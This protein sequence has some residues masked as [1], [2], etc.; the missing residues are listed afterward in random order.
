L[1]EWSNVIVLWGGRLAGWS[2]V[3]VLSG[4]RL[5]A[6]MNQPS[7]SNQATVIIQSTRTSNKSNQTKHVQQLFTKQRSNETI[8]CMVLFFCMSTVC[9]QWVSWM[10]QRNRSLRWSAGWMKRRNRSFRWSAGCFHES[11]KRQ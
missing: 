1:V 4:G 10:K 5:A 7:D 9:W 6:S 3:I 11:T 8:I 2:V